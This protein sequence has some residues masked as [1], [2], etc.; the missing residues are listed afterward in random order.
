MKQNIY[1]VKLGRKAGGG[2]RNMQAVVGGAV[3]QLRGAPPS[4]VL[5]GLRVHVSTSALQHPRL[6]QQTERRPKKAWLSTAATV[7]GV[8]RRSRPAQSSGTRRPRPGGSGLAREGAPRGPA[9]VQGDSGPLRFTHHRP[10]PSP[11]AP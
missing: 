10:G 11:L 2:K 8:C 3:E 9:G 5:S 7:L 6:C 4:C 1:V